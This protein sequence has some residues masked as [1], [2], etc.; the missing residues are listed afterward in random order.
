M[1]EGSI[2]ADILEAP[3]EASLSKR[4]SPENVLTFAAPYLFGI[5]FVGA[6]QAVQFALA[7]NCSPCRHCGSVRLRRAFTPRQET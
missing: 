5:L 3:A 4:F 6:W 1:T 2:Q 7:N